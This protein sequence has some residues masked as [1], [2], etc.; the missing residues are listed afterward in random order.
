MS[1]DRHDRCRIAETGA[2]WTRQWE[3]ITESCIV[4]WIYVGL[5]SGQT[6]SDCVTCTRSETTSLFPQVFFLT[7]VAGALSVTVPPRS[8]PLSTSGVRP[9]NLRTWIQLYEC[10]FVT[11]SFTPSQEGLQELLQCLS[12]SGSPDTKVSTSLDSQ[13]GGTVSEH[14]VYL[15][16]RF[17]SLSMK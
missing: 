13:L 15:I 17:K 4:D 7:W 12:N 14:C 8:V 9:S 1:S 16:N 10:P 6:Q 3:L 11:M 5:D 2:N